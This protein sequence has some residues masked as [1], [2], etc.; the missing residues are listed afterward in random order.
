MSSKRL[1]ENLQ[2]NGI[3]H[4]D[5]TYRITIYGFPLIVYGVSDQAGRFHPAAYML[6]SHEQ[7][8]DFEYFYDSL[9]DLAHLLNVEFDPDFIMQDAQQSSYNIAHAMFPEVIFLM[10][11]FHVKKNVSFF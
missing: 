4:I 1:M 3:N 10:C 2:H 11:Y 8:Q 6:S 5:G 7:E 9:S